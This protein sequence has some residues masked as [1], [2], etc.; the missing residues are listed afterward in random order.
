DV[1]TTLN[2]AHLDGTVTV[3]DNGTTQTFSTSQN[4]IRNLDGADWVHHAGVGYIILD[5]DQGLKYRG[6]QQQ[7]SW[8]SINNNSSTATISHDVFRLW[9]DHGSSPVGG[10]Y[11]YVLM[12]GVDAAATASFAAAPKIHVLAN[13]TSRQAVYHD[14]LE[15]LQVAFYEAGL[16]SLDLDG[17]AWSTIEV[18]HPS[19][20]MLQGDFG[21]PMLTVSDPTQ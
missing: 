2:Q 18:D 9:M 21:F 1:T 13:E 19:L 8:N 11:G 15:L 6:G 3:G 12:P 4:T 17:F 7:G 16:L 10:S 20:V 5:D 14:G